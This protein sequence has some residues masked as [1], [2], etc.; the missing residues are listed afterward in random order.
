MG[1]SQG[2]VPQLKRDGE[3]TTGRGEQ[4]PGLL[5]QLGEAPNA[6]AQHIGQLLS[7]GAWPAATGGA[8]IQG[9]QM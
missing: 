2:R 5:Q 6:C 3:G 4:G 9:K 7:P 1:G 8:D